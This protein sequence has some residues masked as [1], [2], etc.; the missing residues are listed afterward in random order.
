MGEGTQGVVGSTPPP[1]TDR[2]APASEWRQRD[3]SVLADLEEASVWLL[4]VDADTFYKRRR[5]GSDTIAA[6]LRERKAAAGALVPG[7]SRRDLTR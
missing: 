3:G 4:Q 6:A 7:A 2:A 5:R 1:R